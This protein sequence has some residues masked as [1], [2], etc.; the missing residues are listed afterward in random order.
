MKFKIGRKINDIENNTAIKF[1]FFSLDLFFK[2][3]F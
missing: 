3:Y 2:V 1:Y